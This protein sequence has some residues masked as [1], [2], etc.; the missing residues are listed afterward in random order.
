MGLEEL[1]I[2]ANFGVEKLIVKSIG[3]FKM[4][5]VPLKRLVSGHPYCFALAIV[6][7]DSYT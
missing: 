1:T 7:L 5:H 6:A 4:W 3:E 2:C